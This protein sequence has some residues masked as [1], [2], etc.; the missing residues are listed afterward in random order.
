ME[1]T[2][3]DIENIKTEGFLKTEFAEYKKSEEYLSY[4]HLIREDK[5]EMPAYLIELCLFG[6]YYENYLD[7]LSI[8]EREKHSSII[9]DAEENKYEIPKPPVEYKGV[10]IMNAEE[11]A[12]SRQNIRE[13][14]IANPF[15]DL[16][17]SIASI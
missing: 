8:E 1:E 11:F 16:E 9:K 10:N 13:I 6:Y 3:S 7:T 15:K 2:K 17:N 4:Y 14:E 5:P 12:L